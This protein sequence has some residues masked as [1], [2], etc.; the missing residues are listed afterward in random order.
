MLEVNETEEQI[1]SVIRY[2][3]L[4]VS[5]TVVVR[6]TR[7]VFIL[8]DVDRVWTDSVTPRSSSERRGEGMG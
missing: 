8:T 6:S 7:L 1:V 5:D 2:H 3:L 4:V